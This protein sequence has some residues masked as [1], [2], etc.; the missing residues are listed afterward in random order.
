MT[1]IPSDVAIEP[2]GDL[3]LD[4]AANAFLAHFNEQEFADDDASKKK[5]SEKKGETK[6]VEKSTEEEHDTDT[7]ETDEEATD[8][9]PEAEDDETE[10]DDEAKEDDK[11]EDEEPSADS[12]DIIVKIKVDGEEKEVPVK[13]LK[14]LYGQEAALTRKSQEVAAERT[15][16]TETTARSLAAL[17]VMVKRAQEAAAPYKNINWVALAKD[18][19]VTAD[20][21]SALQDLA[22]S[23]IDNETFLTQHL[24]GFMKQ[25]QVQ[26]QTER[27]NAAKE[28]IKALTDEKSP[29]RIEGWNETLYNDLRAF[30]VEQ[31]LNRDMVNQLT[32]AASFKLLHMAMQ[33]SKGAKKV[34]TTKVNKAPKK[35]VKS[36]V[37]KG[38]PAG[39][40]TAAQVDRNKALSKLKQTGSQDDAVNAF[41][42]TLKDFD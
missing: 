35:I 17:D 34:V 42:S 3:E 6:P 7:E 10:G 4:E 5:P 23:A 32:D 19:N 39:K 38:T 11:D 14:R 18:P 31:G 9:S 40:T 29:L 8:E 13:D 26:Q 1:T 24:D 16:A 12:D 37:A 20:Q 21:V 41:L 27:A 25:V 2:S 28:C 33:Y 36:S 30:G 15:K 22:R